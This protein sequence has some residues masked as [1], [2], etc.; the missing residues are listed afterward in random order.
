MTT[1]N[2]AATV[3]AGSLDNAGR[4][5]MNWLR[6]LLRTTPSA[7]AVSEG[8]KSQPQEVPVPSYYKVG[9]RMALLRRADELDAVSPH[10]AAAL[11]QQAAAV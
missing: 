11:R 1:A 7:L 8:S 9:V 5:V 10:E 6:A 3:T 2:I 4:T